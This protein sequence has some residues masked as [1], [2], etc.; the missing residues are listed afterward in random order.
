VQLRRAD[1]TTRTM[2]PRHVV[3]AVGASPIP[4]V[5]ELPGLDDFAGSVMHSEAYGS[6][7]EWKGRKALVLG[8]GTS[9]HDVAQDL[10]ACGADVTLLQRSPTYVCSL[11]EGQ[12]VY[13]LYTQGMPV[14][15]CDLLLTSMP[16][17]VLVHA[18]QQSAAESKRQDQPLLDGLARAGF[19][20]DFKENDPGFQM[21][22]HQRGGGYYFNVGC[23]ELIIAG[24][25]RLIQ[26]SDVERFVPEGARMRDGSVLPADLL[27]LATG[28]KSQHDVARILLGDEVA[29]RIGP[30]W[31]FDAGG[32]LRNMWKRTPQKGL[33]FIA[34]SLAQCR[35]FSRFLALQIKACEV[36]LIPLQLP[37][38][39][40][41]GEEPRA[42][43]SAA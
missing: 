24:K 34:G 41:V 19:R 30:V 40:T 43:I 8:T 1:G 3:F 22:Y 32:E 33:W 10:H 29:Q 25:V 11:K 27:V 12:R 20:L 5:P 26:F 21:R 16:F 28:Y 13:S 9:G 15:D 7:V 31:G 23:S 37:Q 14:E 36:G 6:G 35:I 42:A 18:Y 17:P 39:Y 4:Q 38:R 2:R